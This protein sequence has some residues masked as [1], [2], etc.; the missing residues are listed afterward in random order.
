MKNIFLFLK[1][2]PVKGKV[3]LGNNRD[4]GYVVYQRILAETDVLV[5]YGVGWD[6]AFEEDFN[7][8][9]TRKVLMFDP[10]MYQ[11][12]P[13]DADRLRRMLF[14][15]KFKSMYYYIRAGNQWNTHIKNLASRE[16]LFI[17]E[18]ISN[19][20]SNLYNTFLN[21]KTRF[22]LL[23]SQL[24]LKIDIE[25]AE[26]EIFSD[27]IFYDQLWNVNQMVIEFHDLKNRLLEF[28]KIIERLQNKYFIVHI[29]CNNYSEIFTVYDFK[30][31]GKDNVIFSDVLEI[32]F[33]R[34]N[35]ILK[36][37]LLDEDNVYP[38]KGL[39]FPNNPDKPD[40]SLSF[41]ASQ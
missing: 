24:F 19:T 25:G 31:N 34:K 12:S 11:K 4:G 3:R 33:V 6:T 22:S 35:G 36:S 15:L 39:D 23:T 17:K 26:Y 7:Q 2:L 37:D 32:T 13:L 29:H 27:D 38:I 16:I 10:T 30:N 20:S 21:H 9:T 28:K 1:P 18:G 8:I 41:L 40:Y 5:S 14:R